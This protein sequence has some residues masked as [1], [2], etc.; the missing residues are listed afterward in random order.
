MVK[1][2][3]HHHKLHHS[4]STQKR[5]PK[6]NSIFARSTAH[7]LINNIDTAAAS[8][9]YEPTNPITRAASAGSRVKVFEQIEKRGL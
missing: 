8:E 5:H 9:I 1:I 2:Q 6:S 7:F 3:F 4:S